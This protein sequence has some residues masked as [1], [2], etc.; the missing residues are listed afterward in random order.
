MFSRFSVTDSIRI[1]FILFLGWITF[2]TAKDGPLMFFQNLDLIFHEAGH[3]IIFFGDFMQVLGGTLGQ[4]AIPAMFTVY[5]FLRL[6]TYAG[7]IMIWW[8]GEN[9]INISVYIADARARILPI[10]GDDSA[11]DWAYLLGELQLL[12]YDLMISNVVWTAGIVL[13]IGILVIALVSV[14]SRLKKM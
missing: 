3:V 1:A 7:A 5:F 14:V 11:H 12:E 6:D 13:M 9:L 2:T 8:F 4:L 10:L